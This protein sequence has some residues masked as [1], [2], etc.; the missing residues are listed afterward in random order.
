[1]K[2]HETYLVG[3]VRQPERCR[4]YQVNKANLP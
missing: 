2:L 3:T 1:M 4:I